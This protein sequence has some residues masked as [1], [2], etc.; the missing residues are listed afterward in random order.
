M[1]RYAAWEVL[2]S[3][4][5]Q[6]PDVFK[7]KEDI[8]MDREALKVSLEKWCK[9]LRISTSWDVKLEFVEEQG[10]RKTGDIKIDCHD[11]KAIVMLNVLNPKQENPEEVIVHELMHL[12]LYPM[13][14]L[15]ES[16]ITSCFCDGT[17]EYN[18]VYN[19]FFAALEQTVE[20]L[21]KCFLLE[22]GDNTNLSF[23][24][25]RDSKSF[26]EQ[27]EGLKNLT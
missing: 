1:Y 16:L 19:Q 17:T 20:E 12:K 25:C 3:F 26:D 27:Y 13:D 9:K 5:T 22:F 23:G 14:Q 4:I 18:F 21:T 15:T 10:F 6:R 11:K 24:R 8:I 2:V 7:N